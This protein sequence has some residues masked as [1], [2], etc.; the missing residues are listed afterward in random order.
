[1]LR[2]NDSS[3][4]KLRRKKVPKEH[5]N[6]IKCMDQGRLLTYLLT[7]YTYGTHTH[8][9]SQ[10]RCHRYG[11]YGHGQSIVRHDTTNNSFGHSTFCSGYVQLVTFYR[12]S[13]ITLYFQI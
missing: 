1:M 6:D 8:T 9:H 12:T 5:M 4:A 13:K 11:H 3:I 2:R 7:C 10:R